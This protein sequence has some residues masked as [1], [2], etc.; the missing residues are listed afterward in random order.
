[1]TFIAPRAKVLRHLDRVHAWDRGETPAPV[2][3]EVDLSNRC[4]LG[5][6]SCL[7][8]ESRIIVLGVGPVSIAHVFAGDEVLAFNEKLAIIEWTRVRATSAR[9][10][11]E[12]IIRIES[13]GRVV[14]A[15]AEHPFYTPKGWEHAETVKVGSEVLHLWLRGDAEIR[16]ADPWPLQRGAASQDRGVEAS[17]QPDARHAGRGTEGGERHQGPEEYG[18][19]SHPQ[20]NVCGRL[21]EVST[22]ITGVERRLQQA[23]A[24]AEPDAQS[25]EHLQNASHRG[26]DAQEAVR[27]VGGCKGEESP[28]DA[29]RQEPHEGSYGQ[30]AQSVE[31]TGRAVSVWSGE[32]VLGGLS[33]GWIPDSLHRL[34]RLLAQCEESGLQGEWPEATDRGDGRLLSESETTHSKYLREA[35]NSTLSALRSRVSG[36]HGSAAAIQEPGAGGSR[37]GR[38]EAVSEDWTELRVDLAWAPVERI[39]TERRVVSVYNLETDA[40]TYLADGVVVHNCHMAHTHSR[41]PWVSKLRVLPHGMDLTGDLADTAVTLRW[42]QEAKAAGVKSVIWSGGGEPTTHPDWLLILAKAKVLGFEQGMYTL[43]GLL[44]HETA[45]EAASHLSW[46]VV[47]LD[48]ADADTYAKEKGVPPARFHAACDGIR[49]MVGHRA[50]VGASFLLHADNWHRMGEMLTLSESLGVT[51]TTFRPTVEVRQDAPS[52]LL[53]D[54]TWVDVALPGL[55]T[56]ATHPR[57]ELDVQRFQDW[58]NWQGHGYDTCHGIRLNATI[59]PDSRVWV[60]VNRRGVPGS[61]LGNLTHESFA[62]VWAKHPGHWNVDRECRA[63]C[64]L[65]PVN[66]ALHALRQPLA[67][68]S[69]V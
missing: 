20:A 60:C 9:T 12:T 10:V 64:R 17:V 48:C 62:Q 16:H 43:G 61:A 29:R 65:H 41:G 49:F 23:Y 50:T 32:V 63:M 3:L 46:V 2:T 13:A 25:G 52:V 42:L 7:T 19:E 54:R 4:V 1:M 14:E 24:G 33:R 55:R 8:K 6:Q 26:G 47:S 51:Y 40:G 37:E 18:V 66:E 34:R 58:A 53:G 5:C 59:T 39:T 27:H 21:V 45:R 28:S 57:V 56:L 44:T 38:S 35:Y 69:F 68:E 31:D 11:D 22:S 36:G 15:T 67:H 30:G